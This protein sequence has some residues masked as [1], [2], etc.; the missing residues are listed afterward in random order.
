MP[1]EMRCGAQHLVGLNGMLPLSGF[2]LSQA[3]PLPGAV[4]GAARGWRFAIVMPDSSLPSA[5]LASVVAALAQNVKLTIFHTNDVYEISPVRGWGGLAELATALTFELGR[6][7]DAGWASLVDLA[8]RIGLDE[9]A[10]RQVVAEMT[11]QPAGQQSQQS[12]QRA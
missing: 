1:W 2:C 12:G 10:V 9:Q 11:A 6:A 7:D 5:D 8:D 3:G 4:P